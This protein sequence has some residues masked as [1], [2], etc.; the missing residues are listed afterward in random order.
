MA[1][2]I[3]NQPGGVA[4]PADVAFAGADQWSQLSGMSPMSPLVGGPGYSGVVAGNAGPM[5]Y[6][7]DGAHSRI[8]SNDAAPDAAQPHLSVL[9]DWRDVL[10]FRGSPIPWLLLLM[11]VILGFMHLRIQARA[12]SA[13]VHAAIG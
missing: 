13:H 7:V 12:G 6:N 10:N 2:G 1:T 11:L 3:V 5:P 4:A 8:V 9:D